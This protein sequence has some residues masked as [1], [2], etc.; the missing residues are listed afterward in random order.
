MPLRQARPAPPI[1]DYPTFRIPVQARADSPCRPLFLQAPA[2]CPAVSEP[3][4]IIPTTLA[5]TDHCRSADNATRHLPRRLAFPSRDHADHPWQTDYPLRARADHP[6]ATAVADAHQPHSTYRSQPERDRTRRR[7]VF[8][9]S[10]GKPTIHYAKIGPVLAHSDYP[11][12]E[13]AGTNQH[14]PTCPLR[15]SPARPCPRRLPQPSPY[16]TWARR[17]HRLAFPA[18]GQATP[19]TRGNPRQAQASRPAPTR[20]ARADHAPLHRLP[21]PTHFL[22]ACPAQPSRLPWPSQPFHTPDYLPPCFVRLS[23]RIDAWGYA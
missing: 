18:R 19:T 1:G 17:P 9:S 4:P 12:H 13:R 6:V 20:Q 10:L 21:H 16:P 23:H 15:P 2:T 5:V 14:C 22:P 7:L 11:K 3:T 8:T